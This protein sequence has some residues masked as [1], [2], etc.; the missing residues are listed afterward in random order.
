MSFDKY[1]DNV[2]KV[3]NNYPHLRD[4]VKN[5]DKNIVSLN[6]MNELI[7]LLEDN[8]TELSLIYCLHVCKNIINNNIND[9]LV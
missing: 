5:I 9:K 2:M 3:L 7:D 6:E 1:V 8:H 4:Y